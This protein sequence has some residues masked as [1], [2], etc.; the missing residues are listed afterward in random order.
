VKQQRIYVDTSVLGGCFDPEFE[1]WSN[2]L[3]EAFRRGEYL[4]ILSSVTAAEVEHAPE[5]VQAVHAELIEGGAELLAVSTESMGLLNKYLEKKIL[6]PR[7]QNDMLHIALATIANVDVLVSWNFRHI[8]RLDKIRLFNSVNIEC[9]YRWCQINFEVADESASDKNGCERQKRHTS[10]A[11]S[12]EASVMET[13]PFTLRSVDSLD[14]QTD[15]L[16]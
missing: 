6:G 7:F 5:P 12:G 14:C 11:S 8:V 2:M 10:K 13:A 16:S 1:R 3:L 15:G 4:A 9:G